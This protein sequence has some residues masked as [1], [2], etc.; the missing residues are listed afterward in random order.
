[1]IL[2]AVGM[3]VLWA[4][5]HVTT[6]D[7]FILNIISLMGLGLS[8]DYGLLIVSR[9]REEIQ[10]LLPSLGYR[11]DGG[12]IPKDLSDQEKKDLNSAVSTALVTTVRTAGRT[13]FFFSSVIIAI[14]GIFTVLLAVLAS[15]TLI[16]GLVKA[17]G[18][19]RLRPSVLTKLPAL[20]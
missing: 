11:A 9:Y 13:V 14:G 10:Q 5:A 1:M 2:I 20:K 15:I 17:L 6:V 12:D 7:S 18:V 8:I 4:L 16:P 3:G 19:K